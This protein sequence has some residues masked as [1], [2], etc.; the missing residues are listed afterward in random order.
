MKVFNNLYVS[1]ALIMREYEQL[2]SP[3]RMSIFFDG[4]RIETSKGHFDL[5]EDNNCD[6]EYD[7]RSI[8]NGYEINF[9]VKGVC[10]YQMDGLDHPLDWKEDK[11]DLTLD[12]VFDSKEIELGEILH[13]ITE[14]ALDIC[15]DDDKSYT[16]LGTISVQ[17]IEIDEWRG[18]ELR[19]LGIT[20]SSNDPILVI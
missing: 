14:I 17:K 2:P 20:N 9:K 8:P 7:F 10:W 19:E 15:D 16:E 4:L 11:L 5:Y 1:M 18:E 13:P 6:F 12:D 3:E